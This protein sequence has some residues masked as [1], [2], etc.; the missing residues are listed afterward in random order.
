VQRGV[1]MDKWMLAWNRIGFKIFVASALIP[2]TA[3]FVLGYIAYNYSIETLTHNE[4]D[5]IKALIN[6]SDELI[7][8]SVLKWRYAMG[9]LAYELISNDF[10]KNS[11][12]A[13]ADQH[14]YQINPQWAGWHILSPD[15]MIYASQQLPTA[16]DDQ[17]NKIYFDTIG[18]SKDIVATGPYVSNQR[19]ATL[20]ISTTIRSAAGLT[21]VLVADL[22]LSLLTDELKKMNRDPYVSM[23]L[24][25]RE[26]V[27]LAIDLK[28]HLDDFSRFKPDLNEWIVNHGTTTG[29]VES[30]SKRYLVVSSSLGLNDWTL[31]YFTEEN[32]YLAKI[33]TLQ[34]GTLIF[35]IVFALV[36]LLY[37]YQLAQ[38][39]NKPI[40]KLIREMNLI[41]T[42]KLNS[43]IQLKRKDEFLTLTETFNQMLDRIESLIE[44]KTNVEVLKKQFELK[45]LQYQINPHFLFNTLNSINSLLDLKR[46]EQI[47]VV[48]ESLVRLFQYTLDNDKEWMSIE[49]ELTALRQYSELQSIRYSGIFQ[50]KYSIPQELYHYRILKLTLQPIVENAIFHG[51]QEEQEELGLI[52]VG[53]TLLEGGDLLLFVQDNGCGMHPDVADS[54][55]TPQVNHKQELEPRKRLRGFNSIGLRNVHERLQLY[56]GDNFGLSIQSVQGKGTR[57]EIKFPAILIEDEGR[58]S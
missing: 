45:A 24:L 32:N 25:N 19:G 23:L 33:R 14:V 40:N 29:M 7:S 35:S 44:E 3:V 50:V 22:N 6:R 56:Y 26:L 55:L 48:I 36:M 46:T 18:S 52:T 11:L 5:K 17:A 28:L 4:N 47:P 2:F 1:S 21:G 9:G 13:W 39:I 30:K 16:W 42:G 43:R 31:V 41:Q 12:Q 27:P 49:R 38:Y 51:I 58:L 37:S 20:S 15:G 53:G 34:Q 8:D 57:V 54:L 10:S